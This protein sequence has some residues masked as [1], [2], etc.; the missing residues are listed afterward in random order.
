M[1]PGDAILIFTDGLVEAVNSQDEEFGETR[2]IAWLL[3]E[4]PG[5]AVK[6][7]LDRL[8]AQLNLFVGMAVQH[9]DITGLLIQRKS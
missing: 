3:S 7:A 6:E 8:T 2:S 4:H 9:D 5:V 1:D